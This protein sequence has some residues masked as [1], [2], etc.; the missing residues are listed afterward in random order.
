MMVLSELSPL[1]M[2]GDREVFRRRLQ[3]GYTDLNFGRGSWI[4]GQRIVGLFVFYHPDGRI[5][6][7]EHPKFTCPFSGHTVRLDPR[8]RQYTPQQFQ[9]HLRD[10]EIEL[11]IPT[12]LVGLSKL[13]L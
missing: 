2:Y 5:A 3:E 10:F 12:D 9:R 6:T 8:E 13:V 1:N 11:D 4:N 7:L